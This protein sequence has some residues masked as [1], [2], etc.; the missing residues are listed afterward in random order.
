MSGSHSL[1]QPSLFVRVRGWSRVRRESL[2]LEIGLEGIEVAVAAKQECPP[3]I[4]DV[5]IRQS[6]VDRFAHSVSARSK[7]RSFHLLGCP[8]RRRQV[9][10]TTRDHFGFQADIA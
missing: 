9:Q 7:H 5:A 3:R 1:A 2:Q 6:I 8:P 10:L 4:R